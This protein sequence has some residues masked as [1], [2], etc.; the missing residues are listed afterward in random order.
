MRHICCV[1][2]G[3]PNVLYV[4]WGSGK[5]DHYHQPVRLYT[6]ACWKDW[7]LFVVILF[8]FSLDLH[9]SVAVIRWIL[10]WETAKW[11]HV[12]LNMGVSEQQ[13]FQRREERKKISPVLAKLCL[14]ACTH[15]TSLVVVLQS[16][17]VEVAASSTVPWSAPCP[18][19]LPWAAPATS[20]WATSGCPRRTYG[21]LE[22][23]PQTTHLSHPRAALPPRAVEAVSTWRR[24]V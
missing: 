21:P 8:Q 13:F 18:S 6:V 5:A 1:C 14:S 22:A 23:Q 2:Y 10:C 20:L 16:W 19:R 3:S 9:I 24:L 11:P 4:M 7:V 12:F 17:Q 15:L